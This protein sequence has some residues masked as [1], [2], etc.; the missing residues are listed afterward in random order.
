MHAHWCIWHCCRKA[1]TYDFRCVAGSSREAGINESE[2]A[3]SC[4]IGRAVHRWTSRGIS[5]S[6]TLKMCAFSN[7]IITYKCRMKLYKTDSALTIVQS[8]SSSASLFQSQKPLAKLQNPTHDVPGCRSMSSIAMYPRYRRDGSVES[9]GK[10][11]IT[12]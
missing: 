4:T 8:K 7:Y 5:A 1:R 6:A 2:T 3:G 12:I 9:T 10:P 11:S